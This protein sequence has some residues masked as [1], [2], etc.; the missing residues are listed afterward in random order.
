MPEPSPNPRLAFLLPGN[1]PRWDEP[2]LP[3]GPL[4]RV[5]AFLG[6]VARSSLVHE[7]V[8]DEAVSAAHRTA[9]REPT[10]ANAA[11]FLDSVIAARKVRVAD[12]LGIVPAESSRALAVATE[13]RD[14]LGALRAELAETA[15]PSADA[16]GG[17]SHSG[18]A[19]LLFDFLTSHFDGEVCVEEWGAGPRALPTATRPT[20]LPEEG[21]AVFLVRRDG[22]RQ[23]LHPFVLSGPE[24]LSFGWDFHE[25]GL[26]Y[27]SV[28]SGEIRPLPPTYLA[29]FLLEFLLK[30]GAYV[31]VRDWLKGLGPEQRA[32]LNRRNI[33][34]AGF[35]HYGT[36]YLKQREFQQAAVE[37]E[38]AVKIRPDLVLAHLFLA[39]ALMSLKQ[40]DRAVEVLKKHAVLYNRS[41]RLFELLGDCSRQKKDLA[42]AM[43]MYE[44]AAG[45]NPFNRQVERKRDLLRDELR[46]EREQAAPP[47]QGAPAAAPAVKLEEFLIDMTVEA[48][49]G[50]Y[51]HTVGREDEIRQLVEILS[52]RDKRNPLLLGDPGVGK[53][54]LVEDFVLRLVE[55]R[56]P[57]RF[58]GKKVYLM[59]V[60]SLLAGAKFRGQFEER[61]LDLIK[62]LRTHDCIVFIDNLHNIVNSG[63]TRG[64]TLDTANLLKPHLIKG[65]IQ[66]IGATTH[67]EYR[68]GL[69]KDVSHMRCF[70]T[71][72]VDAPTL[73]GAADM[74]CHVRGRYE[75]HHH[76]VLP[77]AVI[78]GSMAAIDA[79]VRERALPDKALDV[80]DRACAVASI[81]RAEMGE[82]AGDD[83][84]LL[85][86][87]V[88]AV[89]SEM[90]RIPVAKLNEDAR[91]K[92]SRMESLLGTRV[93]GQHEAV[94]KVSRVLRAART[95][96]FLDGRRPKGVFLFVGPT[97]VGK[98]E[99][100]RALAEM[101]F[102]SDDRLIRI[103]MS[104]Y[105]ERINQ[106]RLIGTA[107]G[108]VG[109]NDQN[110]LTD[111]VRK[112]PHSLVLLDEIEKADNNTLNLFLQ[113][114]D[115]GRL[116]D[117]KG[118]TVHF[119]STTIV[120]TSNV[121]THLFSKAAVGYDQG[122]SLKGTA[123]SADVIREVKRHFTPEFL[124]RIDEVICFQPLS[125]EDVR[126]IAR[127]KLARFTA[128]LVLHGKRLE[129]TEAAEDLIARDGYSFEQ[130]ARN[131]ERSMRRLLLEPLAE[132]A[133]DPAWDGC[134]AVRVDAA[135]DH[136]VFDLL[137]QASPVEAAD[138]EEGALERDVE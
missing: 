81:R 31:E 14:L 87:D 101:L 27:L 119:D 91:S 61:V 94:S 95:G 59:S 114:F 12:L 104:E 92:F 90:T 128:G 41:D 116:T 26:R 16:C 11:A 63:L 98:T 84:Q 30:M 28:P 4:H 134:G 53:T 64:G 127:Q 25:S 100:A 19:V 38:K 44:K 78:R 93:I 118:R 74:V 133:L 7:R 122:R 68:Q 102:G 9:L 33:L 103:D 46:K 21:P 3:S 75:S 29:D 42:M 77:E 56:L 34:Y 136:L 79:C 48:E 49:L 1:A 32:E 135:D 89:L 132:R 15:E 80:F 112:T 13:L 71:L 50:N 82:E 47:A 10:L 137:G 35:C 57:A 85:R 69:E 17:P 54:A 121:G 52:C 24:G 138:L 96:L 8:I 43:R 70:Q 76:V 115:A 6:A 40:V 113:V 111:E 108:Y 2:T 106:S 20:L 39:Q 109:Y 105:M 36:L 99:L 117:G 45:L 126:S 130:G 55:R 62:A 123:A 72:M 131:L 107:P 97:G 110:Q 51:Q 60:A 5:L 88:L 120:M 129:V 22:S 18:A 125:P 66:V 83:T 23:P 124:N 67:E 86:D 73:E 37:L 58:L 65:E